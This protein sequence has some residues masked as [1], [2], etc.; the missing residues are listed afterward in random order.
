MRTWLHLP[1]TLLALRVRL[2]AR[3]PSAGAGPLPVLALAALMLAPTGAV[4]A[5]ERR[6]RRCFLS[7]AVRRH[8]RRQRHAQQEEE[9]GGCH[10]SPSYGAAAP[11]Q[12][13][14]PGSPATRRSLFK[15]AARA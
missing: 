8:H 4:A 2:R 14:W 1:L 10:G 11:Q 6:A 7:L 9:C 13:S 12:D 3:P 15:A 5:L